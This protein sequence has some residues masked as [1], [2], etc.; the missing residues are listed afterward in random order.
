MHITLDNPST[1]IGVPATARPPRR[2]AARHPQRNANTL[3]S[4]H[5]ARAHRYGTRN[6]MQKI[7]S[8]IM[9]VQ[10]GYLVRHVGPYKFA[11]PIVHR[12]RVT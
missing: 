12:T 8:C 2:A 4:V 11:F 5:A 10:L 6:P 9:S 3:S 7:T 1:D